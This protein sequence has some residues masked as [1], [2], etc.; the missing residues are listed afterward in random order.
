[1][2]RQDWQLFVWVIR[3]A[4]IAMHLGRMSDVVNKRKLMKA[5]IFSTSIIWFLKTL[6][7]SFFLFTIMNTLFGIAFT[8]LSVP[9]MAL[10]Y[11]K[12]A[13]KH[14]AEFVVFREVSLCL[15]RITILA[16]IILT[17][18]FIGSFIIAGF[19]SLIFTFF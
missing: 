6:A 10:F 17:G 11:N 18:S 13:K 1:M 19:S 12:A 2:K 4:D 16:F 15:G 8:F 7:D 9:Y 14:P 5:G 3:I